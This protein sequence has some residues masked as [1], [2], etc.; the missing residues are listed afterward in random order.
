MIEA[1]YST[2]MWHLNFYAKFALD[3]WHDLTPA[4][5]GTL[6]ILIGVVGWL[7]MKSGAKRSC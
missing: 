7:L 1:V 6:L 5:Y 3:Q 4:K 2:V